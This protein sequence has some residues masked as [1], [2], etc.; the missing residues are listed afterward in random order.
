MWAVTPGYSSDAD[1][2]SEPVLINIGGTC[3][4][5][6]R[7]TLE[8]WPHSRLARLETSSRNYRPDHGDYFFDRDPNMF[9]YII[10]FYRNDTLHFAHNLCDSVV[11]RE[12][13]FWGIDEENVS[14]CCWGFFTQHGEHRATDD[15]LCEA[16]D[17]DEVY[18]LSKDKPMCQRTIA[19]W[20]TFLDDSA[21]SDAALVSNWVSGISLELG[22]REWKERDRQR[23]W[24]GAIV[25]V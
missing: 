25:C 16:L 23:G 11:R 3:F 9:T 19:P 5:T 1:S 14:P 24:K 20:W 13:H 6:N 7:G 15:L 12:L 17:L 18:A 2:E 8:K 21:S 4:E 22:G 10:D